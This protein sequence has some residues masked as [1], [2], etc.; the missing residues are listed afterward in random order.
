M[1][2]RLRMRHTPDLPM[3]TSWYRFRHIAISSGPQ[4]DELHPAI[5]TWVALGPVLGRLAS[6]SSGGLG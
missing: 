1:S 5:S 6:R 4:I 2:R 3:V